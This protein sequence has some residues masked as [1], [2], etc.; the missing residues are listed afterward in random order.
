M[1]GSPSFKIPKDIDPGEVR[2]IMVCEALPENPAD[3]FYSSQDSMYVRNTIGAFNS[4]GIKVKSIRDI[5]AQGVYLTVAVKATRDGAVIPPAVIKE[6]SDSLD[7]ELQ[8]FPRAKAILLMGDAAIKALNYVSQ[9][10]GG[11]RVIPAGSTYK[12]RKD[13][14]CY[15]GI[16]VFPSY[17]QTGKNFLIEKS[18]RQ[19]V[20]ED[21]RNAF[22]LLGEN[23]QDS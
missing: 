7:E 17:L 1:S 19:M 3:Y 9:K 8:S 14:F 12:I 11:G 10:E 16:R 2:V 18:K 22:S 21:I 23:L 4:A 5:I 20:A 6:H 15:K 13:K